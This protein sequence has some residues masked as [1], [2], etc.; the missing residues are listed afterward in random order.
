MKLCYIGEFKQLKGFTGKPGPRGDTGN[1]G[2]PGKKV[3]Y[4]CILSKVEDILIGFNW[5]SW[6][7]WRHW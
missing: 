1:T 4:I 3:L 7:K 2:P 5:W 6:T